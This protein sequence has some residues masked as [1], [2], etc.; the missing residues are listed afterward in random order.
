METRTVTLP[1]PSS[2]AV[3]RTDE[4]R[5]R[6]FHDLDGFAD[7]E[8]GFVAGCALGHEFLD[9]FDFVLGQRS[10]LGAHAD[11]TGHALGGADAQPGLVGQSQTDQDV[12]RENLFLDGALLAASDLDFF[13]GRDEDFVDES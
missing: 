10:R 2:I 11:K 7:G 5:E 6:T 13:L 1:L 3:D 9:G 12:A 8:V 4:V